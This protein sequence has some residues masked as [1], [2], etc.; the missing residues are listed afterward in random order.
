MKQDKTYIYGKHV[1]ALALEKS[2]GTVK[3]LYFVSGS[4]TNTLVEQAK[5]LG[6]SY[7]HCDDK[8]FPQGVD[9]DV[10]HQGVIALVNPSKL[11]V[12][13]KQF[14]EG[15][16]VSPRMGIVLLDELTDPQ[17]VG[18]VIRNAAA[19]GIS[20]VLIPEYR[21]AQVT[22]TVVKVSAG[23]AFSLPLIE[24]GNVNT[25]LR[26]LKDKGFWIYGLT[27]NGD[28]E[29]SG[30]QFTTPSVFVLGNEGRGIRE[31]T[32]ELCDFKLRIPIEKKCESL[33]AAASA[34]VT[35]YAWRNQRG[36]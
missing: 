4:D 1:V 19:F 6:V 35:F 10:V 16:E 14:V 18:A 17:N 5:A 26:T 20:A 7:D 9:Q 25:A 2:P 29:L 11:M 24:V 22:G 13:F 8:H 23:M 31:K 33:N 36:E 12:P 32:E 21:Q 34:A 27:M 30:E 15:L 28:T 3:H